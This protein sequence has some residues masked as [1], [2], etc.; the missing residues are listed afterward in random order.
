M[1]SPLADTSETEEL[2]LSFCNSYLELL[3][4]SQ[5]RSVLSVYEGRGIRAGGGGGVKECCICGTNLPP[6]GHALNVGY[7]SSAESK[8]WHK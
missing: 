6:A 8:L 7:L 1:L 4:A 2:L 3:L 5:R